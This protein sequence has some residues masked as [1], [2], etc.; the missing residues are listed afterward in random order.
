MA[1][2]AALR[3]ALAGFLGEEQFRKFVRRGMRLGRLAFWQERAWERFVAAHPEY[4]DGLEALIASIQICHVH[5]D[6]L[7]PDTVP[8]LRGYAAGVEEYAE[9]S[10]RLFPNAAMDPV[11]TQGQPLEGD[12]VAVQYCPTCR[13]A[14]EEWERRRRR[15]RRHAPPTDAG[16]SSQ[17]ETLH[18]QPGLPSH[19]M[20]RL[21]VL[22]QR[23]KEYAD[24]RL[25]GEALSAREEG[26]PP[27]S[28]PMVEAFESV[29]RIEVFEAQDVGDGRLEVR[30][31]VRMIVLA[32]LNEPPKHVALIR[33]NWKLTLLVAE[34]GE[35]LMHRRGW[36]DAWP[37]GESKTP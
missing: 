22:P 3:R 17:S 1:D 11:F 2:A 21:A 26:L 14:R 37:P 10:R 7:L 24:K 35:V 4:N 32:R 9:S 27:D 30:C 33:P 23:F 5:G 34:S 19:V 13:A 16:R 18:F 12:R 31:M 8:L 15:R 20:G 28:Q 25:P 36:E 29:E 6:A